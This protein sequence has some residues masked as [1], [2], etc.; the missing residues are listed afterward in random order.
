MQFYTKKRRPPVV[1]IVSLIDILAILL[2]FFIVTTTF[3]KERS[4]MTISLP[5]STQAT[6]TAAAT[7]PVLL[8]VASP[9]NIELDG[10]RVAIDALAT[11][12]RDQR[13]SQ[14]ERALGL[15]VDKS[16]PFELV[17]KVLD[18]LKVAGV[19]NIPAFTSPEK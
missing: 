3:K 5:K 18:A 6:K 15:E 4:Q 11:V 10:K 16:A 13:S 17:V 1:N 12:L 19:E 7:E 8:K 2:I 9:E 14:P